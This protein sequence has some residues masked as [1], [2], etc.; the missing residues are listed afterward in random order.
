MTIIAPEVLPESNGGSRDT[1]SYSHQIFY[2]L[3]TDMRIQLEF[4]LGIAGASSALGSR[5]F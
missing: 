5:D 2:K 4:F 1:V 3:G